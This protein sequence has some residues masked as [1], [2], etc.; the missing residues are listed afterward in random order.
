[1]LDVLYELGSFASSDPFP[2]PVLHRLGALLGAEAT[3][4]GEFSLLDDGRSYST[5][6][7]IQTRGEPE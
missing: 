3:E 2:L 7:A 4:Y 1:M 6:H 5:D